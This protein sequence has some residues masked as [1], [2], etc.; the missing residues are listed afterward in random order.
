MR[1]MF[2][3][4]EQVEQARRAKEQSER[5]RPAVERLTHDLRARRRQNNFAPLIEQAFR[6]E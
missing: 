5:D 3:R 4:R 2:W 1:W 6:G